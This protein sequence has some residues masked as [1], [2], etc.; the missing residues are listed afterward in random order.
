MLGN[1]GSFPK[2]GSD[3]E[4]K[5]RVDEA[6]P[7]DA[8]QDAKD[9]LFALGEGSDQKKNSHSLAGSALR[10]YFIKRTKEEDN[11][12]LSEESEKRMLAKLKKAGVIGDSQ[13]STE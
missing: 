13:Q 12:P 7:P 3:E 11:N 4:I 10:E 2:P 1:M 5:R 9:F 8:D 6:L